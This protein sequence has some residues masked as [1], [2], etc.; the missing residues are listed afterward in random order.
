MGDLP[1]GNEVFP[2]VEGSKVSPGSHL[3][4]SSR[5]LAGGDKLPNDLGDGPGNVE[6]LPAQVNLVSLGS[7]LIVGGV[8][9]QI[10]GLSESGI[11]SSSAPYVGLSQHFSSQ[12]GGVSFSS[13]RQFL[14]VACSM[15]VSISRVSHFDANYRCVLRRKIRD[16]LDRNCLKIVGADDCLSSTGVFI[17]NEEVEAEAV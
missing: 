5:Q 12:S 8:G 13:G 7:P 17:S 4:V 3:H 15:S 9:A 6:V 11:G 1:K 16:V 2:E 14:Q 10:D